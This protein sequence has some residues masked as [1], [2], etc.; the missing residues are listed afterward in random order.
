M[1]R[2]NMINVIPESASLAEGAFYVIESVETTYNAMWREIGLSELSTLEETGSMVVY[3]SEDAA[4]KTK[5]TFIDWIHE[6]WAKFKEF[7]Y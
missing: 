6:F 5:K 2:V 7:V 3:E 1:E 4:E